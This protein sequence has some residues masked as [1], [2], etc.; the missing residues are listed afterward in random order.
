[1]S[2]AVILAA[3]KGLR[4]RPLT[5]TTPKALIPV[6][7]KPILTHILEAL[8]DGAGIRNFVVAVGYRAEAFR[9]YTPPEGCGIECVENARWDQSNSMLSL[10]LCM[11]HL[12][13][14]GYVVEGDCCF[15]SKLLADGPEV[16]KS[17]SPETPGLVSTWFVH[18]FTIAD[19]G[20]CLR[21]D[22]AGLIRRLTIEKKNSP[23]AS[24]G[25]WKSCGVLR[26]TEQTAGAL[27]KWLN[28]AVVAGREKDYYDLILRDHLDDA[29]LHVAEIGPAPWYEVDNA[30]D[31]A[32][33]EKIFGTTRE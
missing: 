24:E 5:E 9:T 15:S 12:R 4:L 31:L 2:T 19:D 1:M 20:C 27:K 32:A 3:G 8:R 14:G 7:G 17:R 33:A 26:L 10:A 13:N 22:D 30:D 18:P 16:Q 28:D 29:G 23:A 21:A 25:C 6:A 11:E